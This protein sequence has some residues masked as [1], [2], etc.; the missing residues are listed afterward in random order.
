MTVA[1]SRALGSWPT[2]LLKVRR[3]TVGSVMPASVNSPMS[4]GMPCSTS[5]AWR[6]LRAPAPPVEISVPSMSKR[7]ACG[8]STPR[9][10]TRVGL[11]VRVPGGAVARRHLRRGDHLGPCGRVRLDRRLD[12]PALRLRLCLHEPLGVAPHAFAPALHHLEPAEVV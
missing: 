9:S 8:S 10:L 2:A 11:A 1:T 6:Q 3:A 5:N 4:A 12:L 7:T